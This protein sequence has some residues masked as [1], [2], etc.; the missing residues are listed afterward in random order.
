MTTPQS[1]RGSDSAL[2]QTN[3]Q[4]ESSPTHACMECFAIAIMLL[5]AARRSPS[6][7]VGRQNITFLFSHFREFHCSFAL[8]IA[9]LGRQRR[10]F[11][12]L[13]GRGFTGVILVHFRRLAPIKPCPERRERPETLHPLRNKSGKLCTNFSELGKVFKRSM[14]HSLA[15]GTTPLLE[16][17]ET[18]SESDMPSNSESLL[19]LHFTAGRGRRA[20]VLCILSTIGR[21]EETVIARFTSASGPT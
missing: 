21:M 14:H 2:P 6:L 18:R 20:A 16:E 9:H 17:H 5:F 4:N 19:G 11:N 15:A 1:H 8:V 13:P 12:F 10:K 7:E 3:F